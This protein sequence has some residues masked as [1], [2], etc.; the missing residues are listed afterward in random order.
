MRLIHSFILFIVTSIIPLILAYLIFGGALRMALVLGYL[1]VYLIVFQF[2]DKFIL[3]FLDAREITEAD[4]GQ[5]FQTFKNNCYRSYVKLP[6]IYLYSGGRYNG[7]LLDNGSDWSVVI[8]RS[9]VENSDEQQLVALVD[10]LVKL[11]LTRSNW[12]TTKAMGMA[13]MILKINYWIIEKI[14]FLKNSSKMYKVICFISLMFLKPLLE[15]MHWFVQSTKEIQC[16]EDLRPICHISSSSTRLEGF[17]ELLTMHL[18]DKTY[19][20]SLILVYLESYD[21]FKRCKFS[22]V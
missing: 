2:S 4:N 13:A 5:L 8:D 14:P 3:L 6:K 17:S 9:M 21:I 11:K 7:F 19:S 20:K 10:Y 16:S 22:E 15:F 12:I 18:L 1:L